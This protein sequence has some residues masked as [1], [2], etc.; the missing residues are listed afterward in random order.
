[1]RATRRGRGARLTRI[2]Q[3]SGSVGSID[4]PPTVST[5][6]LSATRPWRR[7]PGAAELDA[8]GDA[9]A[10]DVG[11]GA[12]GGGDLE[13]V[14]VLALFGWCRESGGVLQL[15]DAGGQVGG[16]PLVIGQTG[17]VVQRDVERLRGLDRTVEQ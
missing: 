14:H 3:P 1:M 10:V 6:Q 4:S 16:R 12:A 5:R 2:E 9:L 17:Q 8:P 11:P 15:V 13:D 7:K